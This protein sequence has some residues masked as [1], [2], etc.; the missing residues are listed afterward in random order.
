VL[1]ANE[2]KAARFFKAASSLA[3]I[4]AVRDFRHLGMIWA[5]EVVTDE[6]D[7]AAKAFQLALE[8][9]VLLRPSAHGLFHAAVCDRDAEFA[10]LVEAGLAIVERLERGLR[11]ILLAALLVPALAIAAD[12]PK[13]VR[14][15]FARAGV[16]LEVRGHR[17]AGR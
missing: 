2:R 1:A 4:R 15:A 11:A 14:D 12:L 6:T 5:F 3:T 9:G 10:K 16:P 8:H 17:G 7:F 13:P